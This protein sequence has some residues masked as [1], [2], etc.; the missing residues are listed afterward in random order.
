MSGSTMPP[1][2]GTGFVAVK[3]AAMAPGR[4]ASLTLLATTRHGW[5]NA[6]S[7]A[8]T[9]WLAAEARAPAPLAC[10]PR[11]AARM[12]PA[13]AGYRVQAEK[14]LRLSWYAKV[15]PGLGCS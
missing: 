1:V 12:R 2:A 10:P 7:L 8:C 13:V 9:P 15:C 4:V 5:H 14:S 6:A 3:A 11:V